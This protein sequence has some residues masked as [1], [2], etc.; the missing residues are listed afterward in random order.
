[1]KKAEN[2]INCNLEASG[3]GWKLLVNTLTH[4]RE[5]LW[6]MFSLSE[7][8]R[9]SCLHPRELKQ[10]SYFLIEDQNLSVHIKVLLNN[11]C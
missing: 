7:F 5:P 2:S 10:S 4:F 1:M 11:E 9:A 6:G 8:P 3:L